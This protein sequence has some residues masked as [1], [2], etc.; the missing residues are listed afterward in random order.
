[1]H[2][3]GRR[4]FTLVEVM[5][6]S[7][8]AGIVILAVLGVVTANRIQRQKTFERSIA[9]NIARSY[10][11]YVRNTSYRQLAYGAQLPLSMDD[12]VNLTLPG[13]AT[14]WVDLTADG[15]RALCP[16]VAFLANRQPGL[17][18]QIENGPAYTT[19]NNI[20]T[21]RHRHLTV[22]V[23]WRAVNSVAGAW[24]E[25]SLDTVLLAELGKGMA[26]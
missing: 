1:L 21:V 18:V 16:D 5:I 2:H 3:A 10:L 11:E 22:T 20:V 7:G 9:L 19:A 17:R 13:S 4:A 14:T 6:A 25:I 26:G 23:R 24:S 12:G 8:I 15:Y